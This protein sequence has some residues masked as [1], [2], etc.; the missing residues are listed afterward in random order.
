MKKSKL[1]RFLTSSFLLLPLSLI[2]NDTINTQGLYEKNCQSCHGINR[3]GGMG[4]ALFPENLSR[5]RK[6]KAS[7]VINNGRVATQMPG[8]SKT[9]SQPEISALVEYIYTPANTLPKWRLADIK[10]SQIKHFDQNKLP[11]TPQ[12]EADLM[13]LFIVVELGDHSATLLNGDTF[14]PITRFK[15]RFALHGGPKYSPDGRFVYFASRDGWISKYDIYNMKTVSEI[16]AGINTRNMAIS[17]DGKYAIVGNYLPHSLVIL[18]TKDLSPIKVIDVKDKNG[19]SSRV[20]AVYNAPPRTSFIVALKDVK[21]VWEI[22]YSS[23][24]GVT[25]YKASAHASFENTQQKNGGKVAVENWEST[26]Q[27]PIKRIT[28][29]DYLDDFFFDPDYI[30]LIGTSREKHYGQVINLDR[31]KKIATIKMQGMPHLGSGITWDYKGKQVF[32]SPNIKDGLVSV[33]DMENWQVI[34][35]IKTQGP[36]FFMRSHNKSPYAWVDVFFGPNKE[37]VHIIDKNTLKIVK[38]IAPV[39]GK[40]AAHVEFTKN[41][42]YV[43][44]SIWDNDGA[45]IVY[46]ANTLKEIKRLPMKK[47][48]GK[49]NVYNKT[50]YER[51]TSH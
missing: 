5:L 13:N 25:V 7:E 4:P 20:S 39:P 10:A 50:H 9:L 2:A 49:Y 28:T 19:I 37:K 14:E 36:G 41:G 24:D 48:S 22:P 1:Y 29:E 11:N 32:A 38:T 6:T 17:S 45:V 26:S 34:K 46:D 42:K 27:F 15:T 35:E 51:G 18:D 3:L 44:L 47:P 8:F 31:S 30:H 12:F 40:T 21:E 23:E 33:I 43:L 16:R